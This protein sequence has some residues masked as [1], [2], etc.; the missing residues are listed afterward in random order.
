MLDISWVLVLL[1][2]I[3][4]LLR[5]DFVF[6][7]VYLGVGTYALARWWT[8]RNLAGLRVQRRFDDHIFLGQDAEVEIEV[9]NTRWWPVPWLRL[10]EAVPTNLQ[11]GDALSQAVS[12]GPK[13]RL[14][15]KYRIMG[16]VR[17][18]YEVGPLR[19]GTGDLFGFAE[20]QG[21]AVTGQHLTV[22][23]RVIPL[24]H[25]DL[26]SRAPYGTI[27]SQQHIFAD[28][29]RVGGKR[30]YQRGD[31]L[32]SIDW[33]SSA[34]SASLQVKKYDPA[35]ALGSVIF[36]N[37]RAPEYTRQLVRHASEWGIVVAASLANYLAGQRQPVGVGSNGRDSLTGAVERVIG[38]R[39]GRPHLM[40]LLEWL[41]RVQLSD[42]VQPFGEWLPSAALGLAWG[43]VVIVVTPT[44]DEATCGALHGLVRAGLTP[45]LMVTEPHYRLGP[46]AE[47]ARRL[48]FTAMMAADEH[49][50][51][52]L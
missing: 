22:Y 21:R 41:A 2:L 9:R 49:D 13:E 15:L 6:Y 1:V 5:L 35:V 38:P 23:P 29:T 46:I 31:A 33:K 19:L 40:K 25:V 47:R 18:Y 16:R 11:A 17:G 51:S 7:L 26:L 42:D 43:T 48:G 10:D 20:A 8:D 24:A 12:L 34:H 32:R 28:P 14:A 45:V 52:L 27:R 50:L 39:S 36:L 44:G 3:A 30:D 37:L 4:I